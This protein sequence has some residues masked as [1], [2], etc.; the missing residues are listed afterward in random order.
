MILIYYTL[1]YA[2]EWRL[3]VQTNNIFPKL[4]DTVTSWFDIRLIIVCAMKLFFVFTK[5]IMKIFG[6]HLKFETRR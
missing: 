6:F 3:I 1:C 4:K 5:L 2:F